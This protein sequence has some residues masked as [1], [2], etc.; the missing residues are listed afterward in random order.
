MVQISAACLQL[1]EE[2]IVLETDE[3]QTQLDC[4]GSAVR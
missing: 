3:A 1:Q 2:L 4:K